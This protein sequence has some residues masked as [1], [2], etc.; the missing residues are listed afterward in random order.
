MSD[1]KMAGFCSE[2][3]KL[4]AFLLAKNEKQISLRMS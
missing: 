2:K 4:K 1:R 3:P